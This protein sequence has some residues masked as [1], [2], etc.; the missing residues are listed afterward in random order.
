MGLIIHRDDEGEEH[1]LGTEQEVSNMIAA[2]AYAD[3]CQPASYINWVAVMYGKKSGH[4]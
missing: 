3:G 2:A 1:V 4:Y